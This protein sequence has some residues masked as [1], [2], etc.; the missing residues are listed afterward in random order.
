M[1][2]FSTSLL[3][4]L[5][6]ARFHD[7]PDCRCRPHQDCWPS[8]EEWKAL[9]GSINGNLVAGKPAADVCYEADFDSTACSR[10]VGKLWKH[11]P[12]IMNLII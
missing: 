7:V 2:L 5:A 8:Q 3:F 1:K 10:A 11:G 12:R 4:A 9:N 6:S